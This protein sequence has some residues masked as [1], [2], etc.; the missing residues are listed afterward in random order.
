MGNLPWAW[1]VLL[2]GL[3][4]GGLFYLRRSERP[5]VDPY[6]ETRPMPGWQL[7]NDVEPQRFYHV[8]NQIDATLAH[9]GRLPDGTEIAAFLRHAKSTFV[10]IR[11]QDDP[12]KLE[13][14]RKYVTAEVFND[15]VRPEGARG[16]RA[17]F[18]ELHIEL[19]QLAHESD[20]LT[21]HV[22][23]YGKLVA[24]S[25]SVPFQETWRF[26]K[27][28]DGNKRWLLRSMGERS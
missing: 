5:V 8:S 19:A 26:A 27:Q 4:L 28:H 24:G 10:H 13:V 20:V 2:G 22:R 7:D 1:L 11:E 21:A 17:A 9:S 3:T 12:A 23:F 16:E 15:L 18:P 6:P 14:L 25:N